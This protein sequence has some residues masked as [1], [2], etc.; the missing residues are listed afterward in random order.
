MKK[1]VHDRS[2]VHATAG[3]TGGIGPSLSSSK[4]FERFLTLCHHCIRD[5]TWYNR[6]S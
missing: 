2:I 1:N 3:D 4:S 5:H 6:I